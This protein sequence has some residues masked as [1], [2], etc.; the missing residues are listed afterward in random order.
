MMGRRLARRLQRMSIEGEGRDAFRKRVRLAEIVALAMAL[1]S[2]AKDGTCE[3][4]SRSSVVERVQHSARQNGYVGQN[5]SADAQCDG[6]DCHDRTGSDDSD[7]KIALGLG[8]SRELRLSAP[9][10]AGYRG[11]LQL[12]VLMASARPGWLRV[13]SAALGGWGTDDDR[14]GTELEVTVGCGYWTD[15]LVLYGGVLFGLGAHEAD[16]QMTDGDFGLFADTG[17][18]FGGFRLMFD[19]RVGYRAEIRRDTFGHASYGG[20]LSVDF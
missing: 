2:W 10:A 8:L 6:G 13:A 7:M 17:V 1:C 16:Q 4:T 11:A 3:R 18:D 19:V 9:K 15:E 5:V 12:D 20:L 14:W